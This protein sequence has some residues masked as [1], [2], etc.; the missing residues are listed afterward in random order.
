MNSAPAE[1]LQL[2]TFAAL[3]PLTPDVRGTA[4]I[5]NL[6]AMFAV[7][8]RAFSSGRPHRATSR[9]EFQRKNRPARVVL[10]QG[11]YEKNGVVLCILARIR[12]PF[13]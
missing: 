8:G 4:G 2:L 6:V 13:C 12:I 11:G 10:K 7:C 5:L 1:L 3:Q 9:F